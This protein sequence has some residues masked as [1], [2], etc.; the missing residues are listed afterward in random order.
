MGK[1]K[2]ENCGIAFVRLKSRFSKVQSKGACTR[3]T[4]TTWHVSRWL[5]KTQRRRG[6]S[7]VFNTARGRT[8]ERL[9][10]YVSSSSR[11][12]GTSKRDEGAE[13][14]EDKPQR[15]RRWEK[16]THMLHRFYTNDEPRRA[17]WS[18][19]EIKA[20]KKMKN[21]PATTQTTKSPPYTHRFSCRNNLS[22]RKFLAPLVLT[23]IPLFFGNSRKKNN[24]FS[25]RRFRA[26]N[27][28]S[29]HNFQ[30]FLCSITAF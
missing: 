27:F 17:R 10:R 12:P 9:A 15:T 25:G 2:E 19:R 7:H 8:L 14:N 29:K 23:N 16:N 24:F 18:P 11:S 28:C 30:Y 22:T 3:E 1:W 20:R 13:R 21:R 6:R 5:N 4:A 26:I